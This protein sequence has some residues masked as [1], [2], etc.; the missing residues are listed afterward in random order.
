MSVLGVG[1]ERAQEHS[2][3][4]WDFCAIPQHDP[5]TGAKRS[6][7]ET[8]RFKAGLGVMSNAYA[9][10]RVLVLQHRRIPPELERELSDL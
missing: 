6:E 4:M 8:V 5:I 9:S 1:S 3:L 10:P 7:D 2:A